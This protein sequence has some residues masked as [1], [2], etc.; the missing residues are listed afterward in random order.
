[1]WKTR[2][3]KV[4]ESVHILFCEI[5]TILI[6]QAGWKFPSTWSEK[7]NHLRIL[8]G[9]LFKNTLHV[10]IIP[11]E[12][13]IYVSTV[14]KSHHGLG[15]VNFPFNLVEKVGIFLNRLIKPLWKYLYVPITVSTAFSPG[16]D[17]KMENYIVSWY[18]GFLLYF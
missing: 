12:I 17:W 9:K 8:P 2:C 15:V 4:A 14:V 16:W 10:K 11:P 5:I 3:L 7:P 1:M 6:I 13:S 18:V